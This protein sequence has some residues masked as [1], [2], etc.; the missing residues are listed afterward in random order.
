MGNAQRIRFDAVISDMGRR[1]DGIN[2]PD[3]GLK[4]I[5]EL[6]KLQLNYPILIFSSSRSLPM[7]PEVKA[8]GGY[9][10]TSSAVDVIEFLELVRRHQAE[11]R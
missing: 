4:L 2:V 8:A 5:N 11:P 1:E 7:E 9:G 3:A 10:V 6:R